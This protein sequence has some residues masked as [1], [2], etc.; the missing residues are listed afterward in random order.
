MLH[1][2]YVRSVFELTAF[3]MALMIPVILIK[4]GVDLFNQGLLSP[5]HYLRMMLTTVGHTFV[6][7]TL[8]ET[9]EFFWHHRQH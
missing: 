2:Q 7:F 1:N 5:G 8:I 9:I 6:F 3:V 4:A